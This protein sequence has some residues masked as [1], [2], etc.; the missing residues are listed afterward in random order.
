VL[1]VVDNELGLGGDRDVS[2]EV[3][4]DRHMW[5]TLRNHVDWCG[6]FHLCLSAREVHPASRTWMAGRAGY[7][8]EYR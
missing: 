2:S 3:A 5:G 7:F 8:R 4:E 6:S 1:V